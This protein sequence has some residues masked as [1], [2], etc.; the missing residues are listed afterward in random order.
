MINKGFTLIELLITIAIIGILAGT[1][2]VSLGN[3]PDK[4]SDAAV[5]FSVN[6]I[7]TLASV[8]ALRGKEAEFTDRSDLVC[9]ETYDALRNKTN[10]NAGWSNTLICTST[11]LA[12]TDQSGIC[13]SS[14]EK[15]WVVWGKLKTFTSGGTNT[16]DYYCA[17]YLGNNGEIGSSSLDITTSERKC[18]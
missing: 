18:K 2:I 9:N 1:V 15:K 4:G 3:E 16:N 7:I 14:L 5:K 10:I 11:Q 13:C 6:S 8:K 12:A 17:D